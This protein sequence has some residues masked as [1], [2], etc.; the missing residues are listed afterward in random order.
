MFFLAYIY[1]YTILYERPHF[2][3]KIINKFSTFLLEKEDFA[4]YHNTYSAAIN[5]I[6]KY[7]NEKG[8]EL[9]QEEYGNSYVDAFFKPK[10]GSTKKDSLKIFKNGKEQKKML[11]VQIYGRQ[12]KKFELNMYIN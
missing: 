12:N 11:H 6:E 10:E 5:A 2:S 4:V 1:N 3:F 9:D 7:A 8:Y